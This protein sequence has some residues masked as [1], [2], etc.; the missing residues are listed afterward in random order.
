MYKTIGQ[1]MRKRAEYAGNKA[2]FQEVDHSITYMELQSESEKIAT[3]ISRFQIR[4]QPVVIYLD[5]GIACVS[6][7]LGIM[8]SGN[9]YTVLDIAMPADRIQSI[10]DTLQS[11]ILVTDEKHLHKA[12]Q[13]NGFKEIL[14]YE[15]LIK[16]EADPT[17]LQ[18]IEQC[19]IDTDPAYALFTSGSTGIPKG[20]I[21]SH[22]AVLSYAQWVC[23]TFA[24]DRNTIF[25]NQTPF[26]F[27]MSVLD[28]Y[29]TIY[30]QA[31]LCIIPKMYFSF[32]A[33]LIQYLNEKKINTIYWVPSALCIVANLNT[34]ES[35]VPAYLKNILFAG[36]VMP[37][38][39][40]NIW[41]R[42]LPNALYANLYGPTEVCD[43]CTYYIVNREFQDDE[44]LPIGRACNN[45]DVFL[46][47]EENKEAKQGEEGELCVRGSFLANGY[48][49]NQKKSDEVFVS[50]PLQPHYREMIYRTGDIA[51]YNKFHEL[52]YV[53]RKDYQIKHMGYRIELGEIEYAFQ[54]MDGMIG[55]VCIYHEEKQEIVCFYQSNTLEE[56]DIK[57]RAK[58]KLP[59]YMW[60]NVICKVDGIPHNANGKIDRAGIKKQYKEEH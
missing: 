41:R 40:L 36:E 29:A 34:F 33:K 3:A 45:C 46:L 53:S 42:Y 47:N 48:Y 25:G 14:V 27:S 50:N 43:I 16:G 35:I 4:N 60:P 11:A 59:R 52:M 10:H 2:A 19:M 31:T 13:L 51:R 28:I 24:V 56:Q 26:Y 18:T 17:L 7:M 58:Q 23:E 54:S 44:P 32:P 38:K 15:E 22:R 1:L 6:C 37:T 5:K 20:T 39:Q 49:N 8:T 57:E 30:G 55:A 12:K 21:V 9:F